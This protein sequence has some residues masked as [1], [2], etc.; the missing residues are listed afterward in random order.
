MSSLTLYEINA[1]IK[2]LYMKVKM[3]AFSL[4]HILVHSGISAWRYYDRMLNTC[5]LL[6]RKYAS[7]HLQSML[8]AKPTRINL[9]ITLSTDLKCE[10]AID[11]I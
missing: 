11:L 5:V 9:T 2:V 10:N 3:Y 7:L 1:F 6:S 8:R 4:V